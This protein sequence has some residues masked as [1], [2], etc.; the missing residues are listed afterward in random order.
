MNSHNSHN[1]NN[2]HSAELEN[3]VEKSC[4]MIIIVS[5]VVA[6]VLSIK[7]TEL[8]NHE[9]HKHN[10]GAKPAEC[11]N[12]TTGTHRQEQLPASRYS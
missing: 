2:Q 1:S 8:S 7:D 12:S 11:S 6:L 3:L 5:I 4:Y 10:S 9:S